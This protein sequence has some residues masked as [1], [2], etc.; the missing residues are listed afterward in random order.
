[1]GA[2]KASINTSGFTFNVTNLRAEIDSLTIHG[3]ALEWQQLMNRLLFHAAWSVA[4]HAKTSTIVASLFTWSSTVPVG[5]TIIDHEGSGSDSEEE[6]SSDSEEKRSRHASMDLGI[7]VGAEEG[8]G[9]DGEDTRGALTGNVAAGSDHQKDGNSRANATFKSIPIPF[10]S[11]WAAKQ[12]AAEN[13][14]P[15]KIINSSSSATMTPTDSAD[16]LQPPPPA[17]W[18]PNV[19]TK[20]SRRR[21]SPHDKEEVSTTPVANNAHRK[22]MAKL[23]GKWK[24]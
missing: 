11:H 15:A 2:L 8:E 6:R 10:S 21:T 22:E 19:P 17:G 5:P 4:R 16:G 24:R 7:K 14:K 12:G 9:A 18:A 3:E 20:A 13:Q 1:M 23:M